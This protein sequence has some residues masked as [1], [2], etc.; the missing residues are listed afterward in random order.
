M[1][2]GSEAFPIRIK[3]WC[4][5]YSVGVSVCSLVVISR[6]GFSR[7]SFGAIEQEVKARGNIDMDGSQHMRSTRI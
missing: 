1:Y 2:K 6:S 5:R 3:T 4:Q 7:A